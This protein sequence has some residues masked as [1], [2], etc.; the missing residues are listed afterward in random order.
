MLYVVDLAATHQP[1]QDGADKF[2]GNTNVTSRRGS[3]SG[4]REAFFIEADGT[5]TPITARQV[6][7]WPKPDR[8]AATFLCAGCLVAVSPWNMH[9]DKKSPTFSIGK[10]EPHAA[11]CDRKSP[12]DNP[13]RC[14]DRETTLDG[15]ASSGV[16]H[17]LVL[18][19]RTIT[20]E[21]ISDGAT[22]TDAET[23]SRRR[24]RAGSGTALSVPGGRSRDAHA[25]GRVVDTWLHLAT[26]RARN[27]QSLDVPGVET[28]SYLT[29]FKRISAWTEDIPRLA[30][31]VFYAELRWSEAPSEDG[32]LLTITLHPQQHRNR[33]RNPFLCTLTIDRTGWPTGRRNALHRELD[34]AYRHAREAWRADKSSAL[35]VFAIAQQHPH[36]PTM[37]AIDDSRLIYL[38][39]HTITH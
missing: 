21:N 19:D 38:T 13:L 25:L 11:D 39:N 1:P 28:N 3:I 6:E 37:F 15:T 36:D 14:R 10:G 17:R 23:D 34:W 32:D 26:N 7:R 24:S 8:D 2:M 9:S 20:T 33:S 27:A 5:T 35:Q 16:P 30:P 31:R 18:V 4:D 22:D 29:V 12:R